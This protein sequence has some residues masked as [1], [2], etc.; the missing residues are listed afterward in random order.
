M[1]Q[2]RTFSY[3]VIA[4]EFRFRGIP[5]LLPAG[6]YDTTLFNIG[7]TPHVIAAINLGRVVRLSQQRAS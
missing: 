4:E 5:S 6:T 2:H 7:H 3:A 1:A